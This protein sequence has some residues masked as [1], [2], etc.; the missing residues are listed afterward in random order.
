M[1]PPLIRLGGP[2]RAAGRFARGLEL[3]LAP[4]RYPVLLHEPVH[5]VLADGRL[6]N[7]TR[8]SPD[9]PVA[10]ERVISLE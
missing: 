6:T 5:S 2:G 3:L 10:P 1:P 8:M 4:H 7:E 9:P